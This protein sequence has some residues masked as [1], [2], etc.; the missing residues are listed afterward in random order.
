VV[1]NSRD[2]NYISKDKPMLGGTII[3]FRSELHAVYIKAVLLISL[4]F[5]SG[6]KDSSRSDSSVD[7]E[8]NV[9]AANE[10]IDAFYSFNSDELESTLAYA[11]ES[12]PSILYYQGWAE[13]GN[14][15]IIDRHQCVARNDSLVIC[16]VTVKDDLIGALEID[17]YV[18]DT[19]HVTVIKGMIKSV[20]TSSNDP[21]L[22][23]EALDWVRQNRPQL[24]EEPCRG[25]W[26]GGPTP[27][28]C[29][30]AMVKGYAE[31]IALKRNN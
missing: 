14:Y 7:V 24:L 8:K 12:K 13:G 29:V 25:I 2:C 15:E 21:P 28:D 18:T 6:C 3:V 16:P 26:E 27:G 30:R 9:E 1:K 17:F 4:L 11:E 20:T 22:Y 23:H 10:F 31:F 5:V 19:F